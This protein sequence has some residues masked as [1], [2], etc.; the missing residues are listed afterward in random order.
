MYSDSRDYRTRGYER[1]GRYQRGMGQGRDDLRDSRSAGSSR[2]VQ[3]DPRRTRTRSG[4]SQGQRRQ[5]GPGRRQPSR[6]TSS[7]LP[8]IPAAVC[9]VACLVC[10]V[11]GVL[12]TFLLMKPQVDA[13]KADAA[14]AKEQTATLESEV[15]RLK[16]EIATATPSAT[17]STTG[18]QTSSSATADTSAKT[19][20]SSTSATSTSGVEDPWV[21]SG[22][23]T[24]GDATLDRE[25]KKFCDDN[26]SSSDNREDAALAMY[27]A[28]A[29]ADYVERDNAQEPSG[30][31]WRNTYAHQYFENDNSGNCYEFACALMYCLQYMGYEDA[32]AEAILIKLQSGNWGDHGIVFVT[33][34][35]GRS[36]MCDTARG[37]DGW[38]ID[39]DTYTY[40][41]EDV[42]N[43]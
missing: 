15:T 27:Q 14:Q 31:N 19:S 12:V 21:E 26:A 29:W 2:R 6:S 41:I 8:A 11:F 7:A 42:E 37:V 23:F 28:L 32:K 20:T 38:M 16:A 36:C 4:G 39:T 24:T 22:T 35:D 40:T 43:A 9:A 30:P 18:T 13:A 3:G 1:D 17:T 25:V 34:A 5:T 10:V 33:D